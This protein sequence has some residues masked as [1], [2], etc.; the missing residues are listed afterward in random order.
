MSVR[1]EERGRRLLTGKDGTLNEHDQLV[2][3]NEKG[4][5]HFQFGAKTH[6]KG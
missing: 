5:C 1:K 4:D 6:A 2:N 3:L